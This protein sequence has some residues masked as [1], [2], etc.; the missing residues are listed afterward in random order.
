M[1][2][3]TLGEMQEVLYFMHCYNSLEEKLNC[4]P[5]AID[6]MLWMYSGLFK[7]ITGA[8]MDSPSDESEAVERLQSILF[9][10]TN[11][12]K[13]TYSLDE[14]ISENIPSE[15]IFKKHKTFSEDSNSLLKRIKE[16][17]NKT[18]ERYRRLKDQVKP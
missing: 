8:G 13:M 15:E 14:F 9:E 1:N 5:E 17:Q 16:I 10:M 2:E 18:A 7:K 6:D 3:L 4:G 11:V 12:V